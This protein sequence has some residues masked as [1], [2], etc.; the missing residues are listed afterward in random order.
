L[1]GRKGDHI[2]C[3]MVPAED[4]CQAARVIT[5]TLLQRNFRKTGLFEIVS[6]F[7]AYGET[8]GND[9]VN[10]DKVAG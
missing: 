9:P 6:F 10:T 1:E 3:L 8:A 2:F 5:K 4:G 7:Q